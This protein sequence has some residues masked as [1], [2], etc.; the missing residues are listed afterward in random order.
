M[1]R[2]QIRPPAFLRR[3]LPG[4]VWRLPVAGERVVYLTFDDG[5]IPEVTP[6]IL[7]MLVAE[8]AKATFFCVG[9]NVRKHPE[10]Y[11]LLRQKGM[12]TG[13][14][15]YAHRQAWR[16]RRKDW[17]ADVEEGSAYVPGELFRPSHGQ[18]YPGWLADLRK[19]CRH[20]VMW[21]VLSYDYRDDLKSE[22]I[23]HNVLRHVRPGSIVALHDS[24]KAWPRLQ[25]ALPRILRQLKKEGY[26]L[27]SLTP[28]EIEKRCKK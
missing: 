17:L 21:D 24:L 2:W 1:F 25:T 26:R 27:E 6:A 20:I 13:N 5:P 16:T 15:G 7:D 22:D 28:A 10:E 23:E 14:H 19:Y 8:G 3:L 4:T 12:G 9:D 11:A 18:L